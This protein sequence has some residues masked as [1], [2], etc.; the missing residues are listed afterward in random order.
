MM[1]LI[2]LVWLGFQG[3]AICVLG[4]MLNMGFS[5]GD[6]V[7]IAVVLVTTGALITRAM[8]RKTYVT[9]TIFEATPYV[10]SRYPQTSLT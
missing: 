10:A 7:A 8:Y 2:A 1:A 6:S 4:G 9:D 3:L 5:P